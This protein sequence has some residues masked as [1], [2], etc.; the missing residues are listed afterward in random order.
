MKLG[1]ERND[2]FHPTFTFISIIIVVSYTFALNYYSVEYYSLVSSVDDNWFRT[3][4]NRDV[5]LYLR[6]SCG[7]ISIR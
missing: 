3:E 4:V 7:S 2:I 1:R 6:W 5:A